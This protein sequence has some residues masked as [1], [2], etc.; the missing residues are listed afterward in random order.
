MSLAKD[1]LERE[2]LPH[3]IICEIKAYHNHA[4]EVWC[5]MREIL[6]N[7]F[8]EILPVWQDSTF[9]THLCQSFGELVNAALARKIELA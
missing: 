9:M 3:G 7:D 4:I 2:I 8:G 6:E 1:G 5:T